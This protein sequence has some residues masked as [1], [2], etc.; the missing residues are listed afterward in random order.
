[1][2]YI[3]EQLR[4]LQIATASSDFPVVDNYTSN[5][6]S[7]TVSS[8]TLTKPTGVTTGDLLILIV[9]NEDATSSTTFNAIT[10]F[11]KR[12]E[13]G[14][15]DSG[16]KFALY[17]RVADET[18][19]ASVSV[20]V[21]TGNDYIGGWYLRVTNASS[22]APIIG[23]AVG[24]ALGTSTTRD[25]VATTSTV[26]NSLAFALAAFDGADATWGISGTGWGTTIPAGQQ[27]ATGGGGNGWS[28]A[29]VTKE[30]P[31]IGLTSNA[32]FTSTTDDGLITVQFVIAPN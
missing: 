12:T 25:A 15:G 24:D 6:S 21:A 29:W 14:V 16:T 11:T 8:L 17:T 10:G 18:E 5:F 7:S 22:A 13:Y 3:L 20:T 31:T 30:I 26:A 2:M 28:G 32:T 23:T 1:M 27:L 9:G 19:G 4:Q